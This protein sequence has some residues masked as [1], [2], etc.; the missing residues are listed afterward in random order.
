[1]ALQVAEEVPESDLP[2]HFDTGQS[3]SGAEVPETDLPVD[4]GSGVEMFK[5]AVEQGLSGATLG[6]SK[7][8]ETKL[9][10]VK[11]EAIAAREAENPITSTIFNI[12]GAGAMIGATGGLG[13]VAEGAGAAARIG[14]GAI[15]GAG[16]GGINQ[17]SDDW[18]QDKALDAQKI[19]AS[20][21]IGALFGLAG[22]TVAEK[23]RPKPTLVNISRDA[24]QQA[25]Q[26]AESVASAAPAGAPLDGGGIVQVADAPPVETK[27]IKPTN[28][29]DIVSRVKEAK[30]SGNAIE[31]PQKGIL[32]DAASRIEM[33]NPVN[34][35][36]LESLENQTIRDTYNTFKDAPGEVGQALQQHEAL[37]KSELV[38]KTVRAI[39]DLSPGS[40]P[41]ADAVQGGKT[42]IEAFTNQYQNEQ[43]ALKPIFD[44]LKGLPYQGD[45]LVDTVGKMSQSVP[46]IANMFDFEGGD[47]GIRPYRTSMGIDESTYKAVK[48]AVESLKDDGTPDSF[49]KLWDIRKGLDQNIDTLAQGTGPSEIRAIKAGL[50]NQMEE[51]SA[52]PALRD[53]F[54]RYAINQ[55][56]RQ[57]IEKS[58]GASVGTPEFGAI[59]KVKPEMI[60]DKIFG[61]TATVEAAKNILPKDQ[62][63][64]LL[65]NW[66]SEA[67]AAA[68]DK[69]AFSSNKFGSFLRRNQD[70]LNVAF[71]ENPAALQ[72]IKDLTTIMRILPD[73]A[74]VNPSGTAKSLVRMLPGMNLHDMT[75]EGLLASI[76]QKAVRA[77]QKQI[78]LGE[79]NKALSGQAV[80]SSATE[81]LQRGAESI[82]KKMD[83]GISALFSGTSSVARKLH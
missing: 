24:A 59:S 25:D 21:G 77:V 44:G 23:L 16:I 68:T 20:A 82:S 41:T 51:S 43:Q 49:Q 48:Q 71:S 50:M 9:F 58:F 5:T 17:I 27:G 79:L 80:K 10:G 8:A 40:E 4:H 34:P 52:D 42:A 72:R 35:L 81:S 60:G 45:L 54:R 37:Q 61:N 74:P 55:Q 26:V 76:P 53:A 3:N 38:E 65:A 18:S 32:E 64:T 13:G 29:Q 22:S 46:K 28:Y 14:A 30:Y 62:F 39:R 1:M 73:S 69:G 11:P 56:Q 19:A 15:E 67:K 57:V 33:S 2:T 75:W 78:Q 7:V 31:L 70:A 47:L 36:Q 63:N 83:R 66:L 12:G 6:A